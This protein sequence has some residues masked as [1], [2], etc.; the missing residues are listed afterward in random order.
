MLKIKKKKRN[1]GNSWLGSSFRN[2][3]IIKMPPLRESQI[4]LKEELAEPFHFHISVRKWVD[5]G[6]VEFQESEKMN[7]SF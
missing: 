1:E 4:F 5:G 6:W 7:K 3:A 2:A